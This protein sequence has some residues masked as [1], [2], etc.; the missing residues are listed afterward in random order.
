MSLDALRVGLL[1][2][3]IGLVCRVG[4]AVAAVK[5]TL[6][7]GDYLL[8][9]GRVLMALFFNCCLH[10]YQ[11]DPMQPHSLRAV[12]YQF[13]KLSLRHACLLL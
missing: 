7:R 11:D 5:H 10:R 3:P 4:N 2:M 1:E 6:Q 12:G 9:L 13:G 8:P